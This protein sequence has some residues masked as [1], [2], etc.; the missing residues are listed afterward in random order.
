VVYLKPWRDRA[1]VPLVHRP[2]DV[3]H[4][5]IPSLA[6]LDTDRSVAAPVGA[7]R[8][9]PARPATVQ[10]KFNAV[11]GSRDTFFHSQSQHSH[12]IPRG[13]VSS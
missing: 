5:A 8:P 12:T 9:Q 3:D 13:G 11:H 4:G 1:D 7:T 10:S 2:M 6:C